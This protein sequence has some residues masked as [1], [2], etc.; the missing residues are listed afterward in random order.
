MALDTPIAMDELR[1]TVKRGKTNKAPGNYGINQDFQSDVG[2]NKKRVTRNGKS[3]Y[4]AG[5][6]SDNP[7]HGVIVCV[8]KKPTYPTG[9]LK[10]SEP[11]QCRS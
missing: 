7:K 6:I 11:P 8:P 4:E 9:R 2:R 3:D 10:P 5:M 1:D